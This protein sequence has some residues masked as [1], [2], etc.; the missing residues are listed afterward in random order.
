MAHSHE[1]RDFVLSADGLELTGIYRG[2][3]VEHD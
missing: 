1:I 3:G 2:L